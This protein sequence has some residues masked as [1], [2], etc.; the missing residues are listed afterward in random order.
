MVI[1]FEKIPEAHLEGSKLDFRHSYLSLFL[2]CYSNES[3]MLERQMNRRNLLI[4]NFLK[5]IMLSV[6][7]FI[8]TSL[9]IVAQN[10][11]MMPLPARNYLPTTAINKILIDTEGFVWY[12][13]EGEGLWRDDG[14]TAHVFR[15]DFSNAIPMQSNYITCL[16][17]DKKHGKI[18]L[19][20]KRGLYSF[21]KKDYSLHPF[22]DNKIRTWGID[23]LLV[24]KSGTLWVGTNNFVIHYSVDLKCIS[25]TKLQKHRNNLTVASFCEAKDGRV[26]A[27]T[28]SGLLFQCPAMSKTDHP[29]TVT[30]FYV[31]SMVET[32]KGFYVS[33]DD[34]IYFARA[35]N[36]KYS[37]VLACGNVE[38]ERFSKMLYDARRKILWCIAPSFVKAYQVLASGGLKPI[39]VPTNELVINP[40]D[41]A[42]DREGNV[43][44]VSPYAESVI[45]GFRKNKENQYLVPAVSEMKSPISLIEAA[46]LKGNKLWFCQ[47]GQG[48][49]LYDLCSHHVTCVMDG[50]GN[51]LR[52]VAPVIEPF[53]DGRSFLVA[54]DNYIINKVSATGTSM[55]LRLPLYFGVHDMKVLE[56]QLWIGTSQGLL[57]YDFNTHRL[58][59][60]IRTKGAVNVLATYKNGTFLVGTEKEGLCWFHPKSGQ[61]KWLTRSG[62]ISY[63]AVDRDC[64]WW[65]TADGN[66]FRKK[67]K[68]ASVES[69]AI[70]AGLSG[71]QI[72]GLQVDCYH[73]AWILSDGM[74]HIYNPSN[75]SS[76]VLSSKSQVFPL[77]SLLSL[78]KT[79]DGRM[80][81]GGNGGFC[82]YDVRGE[83][84]SSKCSHVQLTVWKSGEEMHLVGKDE[85]EIQ[86]PAGNNSVELYFSTMTPLD[87]GKIRFS[88]K[89]GDDR[90]WN[91]LLPGQNVIRLVGVSLSRQE[92]V[93]RSTNPDGSWSSETKKIT[94]S[95]C[96]EW[97]ETHIA[98]AIYLFVFIAL[99]YFC[100]EFYMDRKKRLM[101]EAELQNSANDLSELLMQL[102][103]E[104]L[105][106]GTDGNL[107]LHSLLLDLRNLLNREDKTKEESFAPKDEANQKLSEPNTEFVNKL[108][109]CIEGHI[110]DS[111]YTVEKLSSDMAMDR[112]G[113]YRKLMAII[114]KTP[115]AFIRSTRLRRAAELMRK[116]YSVSDAAYSSGFGTAKY[117][118]RCFQSEFGMKPSEYIEKNREKYK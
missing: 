53:P 62:N 115:S 2:Y 75:K 61:K 22:A 39:S 117:M 43:W 96:P 88:Y 106:N 104:E 84:N 13:T 35:M 70:E 86:L 85:N 66:L 68:D 74:L 79:R 9:S 113:L 48:L 19:G 21:D 56:N 50:K 63:I 31:N 69:M 10:V 33:A 71:G 12:G 92:L 76:R 17:E 44:V 57:C 41:L 91:Y 59:C 102:S 116:G 89:Y 26:W 100:F 30:P 87:V 77:G 114:G 7:L 5:R 52:K 27:L 28:K 83:Q 108:I 60:R 45:Y 110:D 23:A 80:L 1:D 65:A 38:N 97:Y 105:G 18:Y 72:V 82:L 81:L 3:L 51:K 90:Q 112:T 64:V 94:V 93:V 16:A 99:C 36:E 95:R 6:I 11:S 34:G 20:T 15:S 67:S 24:S 8:L 58:S 46:Y 42:F 4:R 118:S 37:K 55:I 29:M 101:A 40:R 111:E 25:Q 47:K 98:F 14:Y 103:G 73:R 78:S 32:E 109:K 49:F 54:S 107:G